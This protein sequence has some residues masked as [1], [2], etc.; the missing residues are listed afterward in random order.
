M[1]AGQE[2][3]PFY[4]GPAGWQYE[5]WKGVVYP[6]PAP[7]G[8][9]PLVHLARSV[10]LVEVNATFY[11]PLRPSVPAGWVERLQDHPDMRFT[12]KAWRR[13][14]HEDPLPDAGEL[15]PWLDLLRPLEEAGRLLGILVQFPYS[16]R[17]I[18]ASRD[19]ILAVRDLL[20]G[21]RLAVEVRHAGW[22]DP[23]ALDLLRREQLSFVNI[24][25][26][27]GGAGLPPTELV[28]GPLAYVRLHGRNART[29]FSREAS[30]DARYDYHYTAEEIAEWAERVRRLRASGRIT[31]VVG[32]NHFHGKSVAAVLSLA[33]A[34]TG[35]KLVLPDPLPAS[36]PELEHLRR[37]PPG[38]LF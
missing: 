14:T 23:G 25:Q 28:T 2:A 32:N 3:A 8:F 37:P 18:S 1:D 4:Y 31:L 36:F 9:D 17:N 6:A 13:L 7:R 15:A 35:R 11:A 30:R 10:N 20:Q 19:R 12:V 5:D 16:F 33:H 29:W 22:L 38:S 21:R 26:P 34:L 27:R 24:D